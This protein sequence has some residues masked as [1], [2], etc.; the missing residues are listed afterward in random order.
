MFNESGNIV[1][2]LDSLFST[3]ASLPDLS[4][5]VVV[6]DD[7]SPDG[8]AAA[9][10]GYPNP[11]VHLLRR[12]SKLG[13]G[14]PYRLAFCHTSGDPIVVM[15]A[16]LSHDPEALLPLIPAHGG[17]PQAVAFGSRYVAGG[18]ILGVGCVRC[19]V[20]RIANALARALLRIPPP[21]SP[22]R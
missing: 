8:T 18:R 13:I 12:A 15:D 16:D 22:G 10:L 1:R 14:S 5:E 3:F 2:L 17:A 7:G 4:C 11:S 20:S 19:A 6:V 21:T 9:V